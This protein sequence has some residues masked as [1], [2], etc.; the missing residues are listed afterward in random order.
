MMHVWLDRARHSGQ[1]RGMDSPKLDQTAFG[2][3]LQALAISRAQLR[4]LMQKNIITHDEFRQEL[5]QT[6]LRLRDV[7]ARTDDRLGL[8]LTEAALADLLS[9]V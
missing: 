9:E 8:A 1:T 2:V 5:D 7:F 6:I 3:A 4:L